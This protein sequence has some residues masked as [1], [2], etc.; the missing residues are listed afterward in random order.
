MS[1]IILLL[2]YRLIKR[3]YGMKIE[4]NVHN[5]HVFCQTNELQSKFAT[6]WAGLSRKHCRRRR[7]I[8][9]LSFCFFLMEHPNIQWLPNSTR[10]LLCGT[11]IFKELE[12]SLFRWRWLR[13]TSAKLWLKT[14]NSHWK[15][16]IPLHALFFTHSFHYSTH[17]STTAPVIQVATESDW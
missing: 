17:P 11:W 13:T 8:F 7:G 16:T 15:G 9:A 10:A 6:F 5:L 3:L 12:G 14:K 4:C 1:A 2:C